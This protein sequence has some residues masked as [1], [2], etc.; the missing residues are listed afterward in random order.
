VAGVMITPIS[1]ME[2]N[3]GAMLAVKGFCAAVLGGLGMGY[4]AILGG[5]IIGVLE[6]LTAG[7][8][9]SGFKD[10]VALLILLFILCFKPSGIL[11]SEEVGKIKKF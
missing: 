6:S 3:R 8:V 11:G 4:G 9:S 10:A 5:L 7:L 2:Y 1:L